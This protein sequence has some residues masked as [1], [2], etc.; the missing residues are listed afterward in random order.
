MAHTVLSLCYSPIKS[1]Q[2]DTD[3]DHSTLP[4]IKTTCDTIMSLYQSCH[5]TF[6]KCSP[7]DISTPPTYSITVSGPHDAVMAARTK[8]LQQCPSKTQLEL[9]IPMKDLPANFTNPKCHTPLF[10][11]FN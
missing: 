3:N 10:E 9:K 7:P 1:T 5:I 6:S 8:L 4:S 2:Q 11:L